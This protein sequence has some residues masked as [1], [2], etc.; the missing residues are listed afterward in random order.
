MGFRLLAEMALRQL[1]KWVSAIPEGTILAVR[2]LARRP[3]KKETA[4]VDR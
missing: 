3:Q 2:R 1:R 4:T